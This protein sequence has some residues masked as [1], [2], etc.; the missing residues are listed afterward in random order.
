M[1]ARPDNIPPPMPGIHVQQDQL[2]VQTLIPIGVWPSTN[3]AT[4]HASLEKRRLP[5]VRTGERSRVL[6]S[7]IH[8]WITNRPRSIRPRPMYPYLPKFVIPVEVVV[9]MI[10]HPIDDFV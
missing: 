10:F 4:D 8:G 3:E 9:P 7:E 5:F 1:I 6:T 2:T